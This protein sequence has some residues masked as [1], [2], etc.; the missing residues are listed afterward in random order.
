[1]VLKLVLSEGHGKGTAGKRTPDGEREW[2]FN[3]WMGQG[4]RN[5]IAKY[6]G[7]Q[8]RLVSDPTG[9]RD[10]PLRERTDVANSWGADLYLSFHHNANTGRWGN[11]TGTETYT[12]NRGTSA[13]AKKIAKLANEAIVSVYGLKN[14]GLKTAN[15]HELRETNMSAVLTEGGYMD[16]TIDIK[17]MRNKNK[18]MDAGRAIA[19]A[20]AKEYG[21]KLKSGQTASKPASSTETEKTEVTG[22]IHR[23][24]VGAFGDMKNAVN[25]ANEVEKKTGFSTY[26][27]DTDKVTRVQVGAYAV[28][29]NADARLKELQ[30]KGYK[31]AFITT[32]G[33]NAISSAEPQNEPNTPSKSI[34]QL[35]AEVKAGK[36]GNG[37][38]R[39]KSLGS[40]YDEVQAVIN[41]KSTPAPAPAKP[42]KPAK[43]SV[44]QVASEIVKGQGNWGTGATREKKVKDYGLN[45]DAVQK[46]VNKLLGVKTTSSSSSSS[47][48][49]GDKVTA[50]RLYASGSASS[51]SRTSSVS[52]YV[53]KINNGWANSYRLVRTKGR[54]D[55]IGFARKGD[56]KK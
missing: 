2:Q 11:W 37:D 28:K 56:L 42:A 10:V 4:F 1:M 22:T 54:K 14:R 50:S 18:V 21:L 34:T 16:S 9:S 47:I 40:D 20:V 7:V 35:V 43:K 23:V 46:E 8:I 36:H 53:E 6:N 55:Y 39:K 45:Y 49:V 13:Q 17:V 29:D 32:N 52:G 12:F 27:V 24:Q 26:L 38:A 51:P 3:N 15:F 33:T 41:G 44:S 30:N 5:E 31:D 48:K 19:R 25:F